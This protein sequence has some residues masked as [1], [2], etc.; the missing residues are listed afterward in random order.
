MFAIY[1]RILA[2]ID[3]PLTEGS[4]WLPVRQGGAPGHPRRRQPAAPALWANAERLSD[5][6][7]H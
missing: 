7:R 4:E 6:L 2:A 1:L 5:Y 3:S